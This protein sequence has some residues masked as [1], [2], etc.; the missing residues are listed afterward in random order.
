MTLEEALKQALSV[1]VDDRVYPDVTPPG[2]SFPCVTYQQVGGND[3]FYADQTVADKEHS[4]VQ[5]NCHSR[6]R[7][8]ANQ[9][10]RKVK[11]TIAATFNESEP[12]GGFVALYD[13]VLMLYGT[14]Q[15]FGIQFAVSL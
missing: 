5:I 8:E 7:L 14:R 2:A 12:Y 13:D 4:R 11:R 10:A 6:T 1:L 9:L 15:D 3:A